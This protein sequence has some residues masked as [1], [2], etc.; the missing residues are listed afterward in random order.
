MPIQ[1]I[2][3][4]TRKGLLIGS[5]ANGT[6]EVEYES[7]LGTH[8]SY[9]FLDSRSGHLFACLDDGHFGNKL[10]RWDDFGSVTDLKSADPKSVWTELAPPA[11]PENEKLPKGGDAVL[12]YQWAFAAG[13]N[14]QPGR[15]YLGTEPGGLFVSDDHGDHFELCRS[16]WDH[17]SRL[18]SEIPWMGGGRDQAAIHSICV[19]PR[20][21][22]HI[23]VGVSVAGVFETT[24]GMESWAP[25]NKGCRADF[26]PT[27]DAE[28]GQDPH[29]LV[30]SSQ[31]PDVFWQQNHCGV[32]VSDDACANW[33]DVSEE[34]ETDG[35]VHF[36]FAVEVDQSDSKV[37]WVVPAVSDMVRVAIDRKLVVCR[38]DDGGK[39]WQKFRKGLPQGNCYD[40]AF[41]HAL[42]SSDD[43]VI[44]GTSGGGLFLSHDRGESWERHADFLPPI[45]YVALI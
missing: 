38:T 42:K 29:L 18:D 4:G 17:P 45:Y 44:F 43:D 14:E 35:R 26:L 23:R 5:V 13:S 12:K 31:D 25:R 1:R 19:D 8:V 41:R 30:Q 36:G 2:A 15:I 24:D 33:I 10:F 40:F 3:L 9:V 7:F 37:A 21:A 20:N 27:P 32:Y 11:Y 34:N 28:I 39:T 22:D 16:L 6:L